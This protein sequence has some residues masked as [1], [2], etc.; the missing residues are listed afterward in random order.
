M[1]IQDENTK[2]SLNKIIHKKLIITKLLTSLQILFKVKKTKLQS[3]TESDTHLFRSPLLHGRFQL[4]IGYRSDHY[5]CE[6]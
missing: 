6:T 5:L 1:R 4:Q 3:A 2:R